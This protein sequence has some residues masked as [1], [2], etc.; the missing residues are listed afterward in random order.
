MGQCCGSLDGAKKEQK[1]EEER[2]ASAEVRAKAAEAAQ[3][4]QEQYEKSAAGRAARAQLVGAA[5]QSANPNK[6]KPVLQWQMG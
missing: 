6:G 4:R 5:K 1:K 3:K 2:L